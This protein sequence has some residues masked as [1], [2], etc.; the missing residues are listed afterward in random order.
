MD[1]SN[2]IE[3]FRKQ[4]KLLCS[5]AKI[6]N[7]DALKRLERFLHTAK[8]ASLMNCQHVIAREHGFQSWESLV[9]A[10]SIELKLAITMVRVPLLNSFGI[11]IYDGHRRL[12]LEERRRIFQENRRR[13]RENI[14]DVV[15]THHWLVANIQP[16]KTTG[17]ALSSY[18]LKHVAERDIGYIWNGTFIAAAIIARYPHR[19]YEDSPNVGFGVSR[20]SV[21]SVEVR[22][23]SAKP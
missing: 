12:P 19:F 7:A 4:A 14:K 6:G 1:S 23:R 21:R 22:Q 17:R 9:Q 8:N 13:L 11:G 18:G 2:G 20:R 10:D 15:K 5:T 3:Y 16:V